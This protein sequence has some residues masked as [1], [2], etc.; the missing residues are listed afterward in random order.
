MV[1]KSSET[2]CADDADCDQL[3]TNVHESSHNRVAVRMIHDPQQYSHSRAHS[4]RAR[5][6]YNFLRNG[7]PVT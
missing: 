6:E 7:L 1:D 5:R 3:P 2:E 4:I